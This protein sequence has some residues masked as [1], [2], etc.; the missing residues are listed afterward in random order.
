MGEAVQPRQALRRRRVKRVIRRA[1]A[2]KSAADAVGEIGPGCEIF[3]LSKGDYSLIDLIEHALGA[4][5]P[6]DVVISTWTA[7]GSDIE[8]ARGLMTDGRVLSL[9][10]VVDY[11]FVTR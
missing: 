11:T 4:T 3:G 7:A 2:I 9:R 5:G 10:F 8:F 6:A 1:L